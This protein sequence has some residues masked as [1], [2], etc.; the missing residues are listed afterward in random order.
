MPL[1]PRRPPNLL[2]RV[3]RPSWEN[4]AALVRGADAPPLARDEARTWSLALESRRVP[5][6]VRSLG[7]AW[8][9]EVPVWHAERAE[10]EIR[11]YINENPRPAEPPPPPPPRPR[12]DD[13][14]TWLAMAALLAFH[15][16]VT[17]RLPELGFFRLFCFDMG[18]ARA[19]L[20]LGGQWWRAATALTLHA[21]AGHAFSNA[22]IG[23]IFIA[24]ACRELGN[25]IG[26]FLILAGGVLGNI[27][28][29]LIQPPEHASIGF[30]TAVFAAAAILSGLRAARGGLEFRGFVA[31]VAAGL[32]ILAM[33]GSAGEHTDL[34]AHLM[35][36]AVGLVL[37]LAAGVLGRAVEPPA[38]LRRTMELAALALLPAAWAWAWF[39]FNA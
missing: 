2:R 11:Q 7:R 29:A 9:V 21:D 36:F 18:P 27:C 31:P 26:W 10:R 37:G 24:L 17:S 16:L 38:W 8:L 5:H 30:S 32:G 13:L 34:G 28:N 39:W 12:A 4:L 1:P 19:A 20:I 23:G 6:R 14:P 33:L 3:F 35:G 15:A 22:V 25:G